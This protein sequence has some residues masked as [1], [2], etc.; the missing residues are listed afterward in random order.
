MALAR[1]ALG[2]GA[3][4]V[5][6]T[7]VSID[8]ADLVLDLGGARG[9]AAGDLV[10]LWRPLRIKHPV[11]GQL[12]VDRFRVGT[13]RV[14]SVQRVLSLARADGEPT[15]SPAVG[16]VV[17]LR[18]RRAPAAPPLPSP[19]GS[20]DATPPAAPAVSAPPAAVEDP[21]A[22]ALSR[23]FDELRGAE[24]QARVRRYQEFVAAHPDSRF[25]AVLREEAVAMRA[26]RPQA[27]D[28][29]DTVAVLAH[30]SP[31]DVRAG[32]PLRLAFLVRGARAGV[33]HVKSASSA[34]YVS[35][36][37][38]EVGPGYLAAG[39]PA[40]LV[41]APGLSYF[42]EATDPSGR[43]LPLFRS[44]DAPERVDVDD[45]WAPVDGKRALSAALFG[46][47][48]FYG[49]PSKAND[50]VFQTEGTFGARFGDVGV[51]ALRSGFGVF[52]GAGGSL[53]ELDQERA[54]P[55]KVGLTYGHVELEFAPVQSVGFIG[56]AIVGLRD[57]GVGGGAQAF[58]RIGHD[59]A[60]NLLLGG[61]VLGG[62]GL[63]GIAE[64]SWR[65][66]PRV[67]VVLRTEVTNQP[68]GTGSPSADATDAAGTARGKSEV[69]AR[70]LAQVGYQ[71]TQRLEL[72]IRAS[73][74]GRTIRHAGPGFG[75]G[76]T[77]TW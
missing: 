10:E 17:I 27:G 56:R 76:V 54:A 73:Y 20:S 1:A 51:R 32:A 7:L 65:T 34:A 16:D 25:A 66:I 21:D 71:L 53:R 72:A 47:Y 48:A 46:E 43:A 60:S 6:G 38:R 45:P 69:G 39:L 4:V 58:V 11:T 49:P 77:Y 37:L 50:Y 36:P 8:G 12:L 28:A 3:E 31:K 29:K 41:T 23:L 57:D 63:R 52:R 64:L 44:A 14:G 24:P 59:R 13:L 42:A 62:V 70:A 9:A 22:A 5:E 67:P 61:E 18:R 74:Q 2:D 75:A 55:R 33:L 15:R 68:A 30:A 40:A 35:M 26:A 19:T